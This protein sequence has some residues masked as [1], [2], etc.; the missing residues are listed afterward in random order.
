MCVFPSRKDMS[1]PSLTNQAEPK[2]QGSPNLEVEL[3]SHTQF[4]VQNPRHHIRSVLEWPDDHG[5]FKYQ[6][7]KDLVNWLTCGSPWVPLRTASEYAKDTK[8]QR[9]HSKVLVPQ[10]I[11][12]SHLSTPFPLD[13]FSI[14]AS[15]IFFKE[16]N[17]LDTVTDIYSLTSLVRGQGYRRPCCSH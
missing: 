16:Q 3:D 8:G 1:R 10:L 14:F 13:T 5:K 2:A 9:V 17:L 7:L 11:F 4:P 15:Y 12:W 6:S